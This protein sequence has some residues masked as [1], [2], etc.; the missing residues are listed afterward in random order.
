MLRHGVVERD[1][2]GVIAFDR[3]HAAG[4]S[5]AQAF[6]H[7]EQAEIGIGQAIPDEDA[8]VVHLEKHSY[9]PRNFGIRSRRNSRARRRASGFWSS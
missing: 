9:Q 1:D 2:T 5:V 4:D 8:V 6:H 7:L 3:T